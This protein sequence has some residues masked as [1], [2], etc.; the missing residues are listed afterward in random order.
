MQGSIKTP[1]DPVAGD[2]W[3]YL[4]EAGPAQPIT[5]TWGIAFIEGG[6]KQPAAITTDRL[7]SWTE[8][9]DEGRAFSGTARYETSFD[10][11]ATPADEWVLDLGRVHESARVAI[12]GQSLG[13]LWHRPFRVPIGH[14]LRGGKNTLV[15]EVTNLMANRIADMDR[16]KI[17][18]RRYF[19]VDINYQP[20][21]ASSWAP[22]PSGLL[23]PVQLIPCT[24][25]TPGTEAAS[26]DGALDF[27]LR[28]RVETSQ[29]CGRF[30]VV[31]QNARWDPKKT[32]IVICDMWDKHWC[33]GATR[34]VAEMAP[35]INDVITE[36]RKR[37][38]LII[39]APSRALEFYEETPQRQ[40]AR[41]APKVETDVPLKD[42]CRLDPN[43]EPPLPIDDSD[44]GCDCHPTCTYFPERKR[45]I[46]T[47]KIKEGDAVTD[48]VEACYLLEQRGIENVIIMGVHANMCVLNRPFG[49][50]QAVYQGKNVVLMRDLTDSMY[51]PSRPPHVDHFTGTDL[52]IEHI[53]KYWCPTITSADILGGKPFRF[54]NDTRPRQTGSRGPVLEGGTGSSAAGSESRARES[55]EMKSHSR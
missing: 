15:I 18:W 42:R 34:R 19:F 4:T 8:L 41:N 14:A 13:T 38:V 16:R 36:A 55:G 5:S 6:A 12:N 50:R 48:S 47:I 28:R 31:T 21:D 35:R 45:Q 29:G 54:E 40:V 20:F 1:A 23:G 22:M 49:I 26:G 27:I 39:H 46:E 2:A 32:A 9:G 25:M 51:N 11:S 30:R 33:E 10:K 24:T 3:T 37:G 17:N 7:V 52:V 53:E 44:G 43:R